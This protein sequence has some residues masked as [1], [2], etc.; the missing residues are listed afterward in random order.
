MEP[1]SLTVLD[2]SPYN[3][4]SLTCTATAETTETASFEWFKGPT[5]TETQLLAGPNVTITTNDS[6]GLTS[7]S[8]LTSTEMLAA[9]LVYTCRVFLFGVVSFG[10]ASVTVKGV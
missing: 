10:L 7:S 4:V 9:D 5:G 2:T 1:R 3:V 6:A 8:S